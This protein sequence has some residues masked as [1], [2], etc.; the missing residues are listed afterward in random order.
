MLDDDVVTLVL[1][2]HTQF[3]EQVVR[4]LAHNHGAEELASQPGATA[5]RHTLLND[6]HLREDGVAF[7]WTD[8]QGYGTLRLRSYNLHLLTY[9]DVWVLAELVGA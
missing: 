4:G 8:G 9:L 1:I 5:W 2:W 7:Q 3:V 6:G